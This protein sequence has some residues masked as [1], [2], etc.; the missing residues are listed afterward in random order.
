MNCSSD[1]GVFVYKIRVILI[2]LI[3]IWILIIAF[4][5]FIWYPNAYLILLL[6]LSHFLLTFAIL[7][8]PFGFTLLFFYAFN[9]FIVL[10]NLLVLLWVIVI[11]SITFGR[12]T[13]F[14]L[15]DHFVTTKILAWIFCSNFSRSL[16]TTFNIMS[17]GTT[18]STRTL[19]V[20]RNHCA[21]KASFHQ[22]SIHSTFTC[23][24]KTSLV[25]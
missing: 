24:L 13:K 14:L 16:N 19:A 2:T 9:H 17:H 18:I 15:L 12:I 23:L 11:P 6:L 3:K 4:R 7:F 10:N 22:V 5:T 8:L 1:F 20:L 21:W 25:L